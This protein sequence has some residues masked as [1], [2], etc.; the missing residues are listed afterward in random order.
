MLVQP[1]LQSNRWLRYVVNV[2]PAPPHLVRRL[3]DPDAGWPSSD[4][5]AV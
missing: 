2:E 1:R 3:L 4:V 5:P